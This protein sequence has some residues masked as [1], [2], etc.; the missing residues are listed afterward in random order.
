[1][2]L[3]SKN[4]VGQSEKGLNRTLK[5]AETLYAKFYNGV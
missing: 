1:M 4:K 3:V 5:A 2:H